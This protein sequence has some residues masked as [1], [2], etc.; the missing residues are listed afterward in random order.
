MN[1]NRHARIAELFRRAGELEP[2]DRSRLLNE[3]CRDDPEL[4]AEVER[5]LEHDRDSDSLPGKNA[6][7]IARL[8]RAALRD[9][10]VL[11]DRIGP[12]RILRH[13]GSGGMGEVYLVEQ[14]QP[15]RR[16]VALKL[17]KLGMDTQAVISRFEAER[18]ALALMNHPNVAQVFDAGTTKQGR[19]YFVMEFVEGE[20]ITDH[21]DR[22]RL[23]TQARLELFV[24]VC[25]GV[26]HAHQKG[27][28]HRDLKPSN[29]LV[30]TE[31]ET[32]V[33]K[34]IDFGVAKATQ[35]RLTERSAFTE[36]GQLIGTPEYMS[37]EQAAIDSDDIDTRTDVYSLGVLLYELLVGALPFDPRELRR[38][39][40]DELRRRIREVEPPKPSRRLTTLGDAAYGPANNR[41]TNPDGLV[42]LLRGEL[43]WITMKA[44]E[45]DRTRRYAS[46]A[47]LAAEIRRQMSHEPV[48]AGPPRAAYRARKFVR[49]H[50]A[51]VTVAIVTGLLIISLAV[52]ERIQSRRIVTEGDTA[53]RVVKFMERIFQASDP[54]EAR[55]DELTVREM[56][57]RSAAAIDEELQ[58]QPRV[59]ARLML[60]MGGAYQSLGLFSEAASLIQRAFELL[61]KELGTD[62]P[63]TLLAMHR[64]VS[65]YHQQGRWEESAVLTRT[66]LVIHERELGSDHEATLVAKDR[67]ASLYEHEGRFGEAEAFRLGVLEKRR[68]TLGDSHESTLASMEALATLYSKLGRF[69]E[70][71]SLFNDVIQTRARVLHSDHPHTLGTMNNLAAMHMAQLH[72]GRAK[73]LLE[74][75]LRAQER[76]LGEDHPA[77]L[78][79]MTNLAVVNANTDQADEAH[80]IVVELLSRRKRVA[81]SDTAGAQEKNDAA[82]AFLACP[83]ADLRNPPL[84]LRFAMEANELDRFDNSDHLWTLCLAYH[85]NG[86][87]MEAIECRNRAA[88]RTPENRQADSQFRLAQ[89]LVAQGMWSEAE[90]YFAKACE[91]G[92]T[93]DPCSGSAYA[94]QVTGRVDEAFRVADRAKALPPSASGSYNLACTF[95]LQDRKV[96]ALAALRTSV[97]LGYARAG[98]AEDPDLRTLHEEPAFEAL[99]KEVN[100]RAGRRPDN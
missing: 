42:R 49:R 40:F 83:P 74:E 82:L 86:K 77:T 96:E 10:E 44:L 59:Q 89:F 41:R 9:G 14:E 20:S 35:Q 33:P 30:A 22:H 81:E 93:Q 27:I 26:Q 36:V 7:E 80:R 11:P 53:E 18:Q 91:L 19:P 67:V 4:R 75:I 61:R 57:D 32:A 43:D 51:G 50:R 24:R 45:K 34:I 55:E 100:G 21:C 12:Y 46:P 56:L 94:L 69:E 84:G 98:I 65:I 5:L 29:V 73:P 16:R 78:R 97:E 31:D 6:G 68:S 70:A 8:A 79:S 39:G 66:L 13:L 58:G 71:Q 90:P 1:Q 3:V 85:V 25:E 99:L 37:P 52:R 2:E 63:W 17:I 60:T 64:L 23:S 47:D 76:V 72:F 92:R 28:I 38:A 95:A 87:T 15:I 54:A 88:A 48:L 62:H